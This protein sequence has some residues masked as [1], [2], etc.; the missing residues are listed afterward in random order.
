MLSMSILDIKDVEDYDKDVVKFLRYYEFP[1]QT[2]NFEGSSKYEKLK[3]KSDYDIILFIKNTTPVT[4]VFN[5]LRKV[6]QKIEKDPDAYFIELKMQTKD[7]KK[8][9]WYRGELF[10]ISDFEPH[11]NDNLA[12]FK[13]D[14]VIRV[15]DEFF[16]T[17]GTY[18]M[19]PVMGM[20]LEKVV[21]DLKENM[22]KHVK[23]GNYYKGL[24]RMFSIYVMFK[25][26]SQVEFPMK[27]FNT[28]MG[29]LYEIIC[30]LQA[31]ELVSELIKMRGLWKI[32]KCLELFISH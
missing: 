22:K 18:R 13:I 1:G 16:E 8:F 28:D 23:E 12:F 27:I 25:N 2:I 26:M 11:Y 19:V 20:S 7:E 29:K 9:K 31:V 5:N 4:E 10:T 14:M 15:K 32:R 30:I 24:K 6:L 21:K 17:S 3:Y